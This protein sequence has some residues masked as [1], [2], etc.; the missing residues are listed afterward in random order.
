MGE[1]AVNLQQRAFSLFKKIY[2]E[3]GFFRLRSL[4][5]RLYFPRRTVRPDWERLHAHD[6]VVIVGSGIA[7]L[8]AAEELHRAGVR[9]ITLV[10][11]ELSPG[12]KCVHQGCM[13][14]EFFFWLSQSHSQWN[15]QQ[16]LVALREFTRQLSQDVEKKIMAFGI[17][18]IQ[19]QAV[20]VESKT[21]HTKRGAIEFDKCI[22]A[23]GNIA[24]AHRLLER[25]LSLNDF[26]DFDYSTL[27]IVSDG[28][29]GALSL[30]EMAREMGCTVTLVLERLPLLSKTPSFK[31]LM[32]SLEKLGVTIV[33]GRLVATSGGEYSVQTSL[34]HLSVSAEKVMYIGMSQPN[35]PRVDGHALNVFQIDLGT[36]VVSGKPYLA[37]VG[38]AAGFLSAREAEIHGKNLVRFWVEGIRGQLKEIERLPF[39]LH[40]K[41]SLACVGAPWTYL[42]KDFKE[43][44]FQELGWTRVSQEAGKLW[45]QV[46]RGTGTVQA[47]HLVH[48]RASDL[49]G[50]AS[51][52][53][54]VPFEDPRWDAFSVHP[55]A[56]EI[57]SLIRDREVKRHK[58]RKQ[59]GS[60]D[61]LQP[62][63]R[64]PDPRALGVVGQWREVLTPEEVNFIL[65]QDRPELYFAVI[66]AVKEKLGLGVESVCSVSSD[67]QGRVICERVASLEVVEDTEKSLL[68]VV[69]EGVRFPFLVESGVGRV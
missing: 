51:F 40:G 32:R 45:Y 5:G 4:G 48:E 56:F 68:E 35:L 3:D 49:I 10:S 42:T 28:N 37:M 62:V 24:P 7:G 8:T 39:R 1:C 41:R 25:P 11:N 53:L 59:V 15:N 30:A 54:G 22:W 19:T 58:A 64:L 26:W 66:S 23:G 47:I 44:D 57:F 13:P 67:E 46:D 17:Q 33:F 20:A 38:D 16:R 43:I 27:L 61:E 36:G 52:L 63:R 18:V 29:P 21:L 9:R 55:S 65:L 60:V 12:G 6:R 2:G 69:V 50:A 31:Y 34:G 14:S